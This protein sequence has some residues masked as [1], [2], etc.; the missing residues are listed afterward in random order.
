MLKDKL[1]AFGLG[2]I[3][4][5]AEEAFEKRSGWKSTDVKTT[6]DKFSHLTRTDQVLLGGL[7]VGKALLGVSSAVTVKNKETKPKAKSD[8]ASA[9]G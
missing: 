9:N 2:D 5:K 7:L 6:L 3:M 1:Q 4:S 8:E